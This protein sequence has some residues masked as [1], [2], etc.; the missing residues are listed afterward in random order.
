MDD[1]RRGKCTKVVV[2]RLDRLGRTSSGLHQLFEEF[3]RL[4]VGLV[5]LRD[6]F[7]L[8]T[9]SG[10]LMAGVL[11]SVAVYETEVR[12]ERQIAGIAA[13]RAKGVRWGGSKPGRRIRVT[14]EKEKRAC[15]MYQSGVSK[16]EISRVVGIG[17]N[18][19][20][21]VLFRNGLWERSKCTKG[22]TV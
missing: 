3:T 20:D 4:G 2:W 17:R 16:S 8:T 9:P 10:R 15:E 12:K 18:T 19:L 22:P 11:A 1:V 5:S 13:A 14:E 6:G 21:K 7:D